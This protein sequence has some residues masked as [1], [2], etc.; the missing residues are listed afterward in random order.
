MQ[1]L[2]VQMLTLIKWLLKRFFN[3]L[4]WQKDNSILVCHETSQFE[5]S[6]SVLWYSTWFPVTTTWTYLQQNVANIKQYTMLFSDAQ[7][8]DIN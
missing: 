1:Q 4:A 6:F 3:W 5:T 7:N 8:N 2:L